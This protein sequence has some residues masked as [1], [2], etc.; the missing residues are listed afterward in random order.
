MESSPFLLLSL[1]T[2]EGAWLEDAFSGRGKIVL[3]SGA[4]YTG[5][6]KGGLYEGLGTYDDP[7]A[8]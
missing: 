7:T 3:R 8:R 2:Y 1:Q 5:E 6:F 4:T